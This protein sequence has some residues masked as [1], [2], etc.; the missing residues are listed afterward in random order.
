MPELRSIRCVGCEGGIPALTREEIEKL[1][2]Q[3]KDWQVDSENKSIS[4]RFTFKGFYKTMAFVN[5]IAWI[6]NQENHHPDL[7]VGYNYCNV[8]Y[9]THAVSGLTQNDFICAAKIDALEANTP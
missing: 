3:V 6:A 5:A 8:K 2:P 1:M 7:E 4:R 9:T